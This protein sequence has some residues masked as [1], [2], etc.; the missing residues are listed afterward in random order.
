MSERDQ[1]GKILAASLLSLSCPGS[2]CLPAQPL[3]AASEH[4]RVLAVFAHPDDETMAGALLAHYAHTPGTGV[5]LA[6]VTNGEKGVMPH[7]RLSAG[8]ELA[9]VRIKEAECACRVLGA[10]MPIL[11]GMPD[12]GLNS[13]RVLAE[14]ASKLKKTIV[15]VNPHAI[16]T[17]GPDGGYGHPDHRLVSAVVTQI[18][19]ETGKP[20]LFYAALPNSRMPESTSEL[21][22][23]APFVATSD[24]YLDTRVR[25]SRED[26]AIARRSLAC[27]QSQFTPQSMDRI[28]DITEKVNGGTA[29]LRSWSSGRKS[30][31]LFR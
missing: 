2:T 18:V 7:T 24:Q 10:H 22:F 13:V 29:Y 26:E 3:G 4:R 12:G 6:I 15:D 23:P 25:V 16:V 5:Y 31:D 30:A 27:H 8:E 21:R 20:R 1:I 28:S 14:L 9:A 19:Q 17:W 11:L